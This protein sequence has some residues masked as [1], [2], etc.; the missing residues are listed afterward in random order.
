M[1]KLVVNGAKLKCGEG[2]APS[3]LTILPSNKADATDLPVATKLDN[4]AMVN[5]APFGMCKTQAN[6]QVATATSNAG[7]TLTPQP[8]VPIIPAQWSDGSDGVTLKGVNVLTDSSTCTC[9][10]GGKIEI[11]DPGNPVEVE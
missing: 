7:G 11:T 9:Q 1:P 2:M 6:P 10:W 8:C 5:I 3:T 4:K